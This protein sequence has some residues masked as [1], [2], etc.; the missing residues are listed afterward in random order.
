MRENH[1]QEGRNQCHLSNVIHR[2]GK[3]TV[4]NTTLGRPEGMKSDWRFPGS[5]HPPAATSF[6]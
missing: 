4:S 1:Q 3:T 6:I 2:G 5:T